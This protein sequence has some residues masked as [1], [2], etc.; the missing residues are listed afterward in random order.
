MV[1]IVTMYREQSI[2]DIISICTWGSC[3]VHTAWITTIP[4]IGVHLNT[5]FI[6]CE[7][8]QSSY[9][10][11]G[12]GNIVYISILCTTPYRITAKSSVYKLQWCPLNQHRGLGK[13][14]WSHIL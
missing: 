14:C 3:S 1:T 9:V 11:R 2:H 12:V 8:T 5:A 6:L 4:V 7:H 13:L 10:R